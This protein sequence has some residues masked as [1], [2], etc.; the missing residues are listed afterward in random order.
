MSTTKKSTGSLPSARKRKP[1]KTNGSHNGAAEVLTLA[2]A[3]A[4]L[5]VSEDEILRMVGPAGL[6]GRRIGDEWRFL[7][8]S[9]QEWLGRPAPRS[10]KEILLSM[11]GAWKDDPNLEEL[12]AEI[13]QER[14]RPMTEAGQ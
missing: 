11:A 4:Y 14:G 6:P 9:L 13:Y 7:K 2:E 12:L 1:V 3:A 10:G 5:R 8:S